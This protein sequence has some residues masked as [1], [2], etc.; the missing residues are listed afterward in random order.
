MSEP[1]QNSEMEEYYQRTRQPLFRT[2]TTR[3][4]K[5]GCWML[6]VLWFCLLT[7]PLI[8]FWLASGRSITV[9][10]G[11]IPAS[12]QYPH[13]QL[14]LI[15]NTDNRGLQFTN[16]SVERNSPTNLCVETDVNYLLWAREEAQNA[17]VFCDCYERSDSGTDWVFVETLNTTCNP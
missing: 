12:E 6:V 17:A 10:R 5:L 2:P 7:L 1:Q 8:M 13:F 9:P 11:G 4:G 3:F 16:T 14:S 15:M